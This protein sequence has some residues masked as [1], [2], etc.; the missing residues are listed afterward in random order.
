MQTRTL[1]LTPSRFITHVTVPLLIAF[2][3][4]ASGAAYAAKPAS[5]KSS[6]ESARAPQGKSGFP[7]ARQGVNMKPGTGLRSAEMTADADDCDDEDAPIAHAAPSGTSQPNPYAAREPLSKSAATAQGNAG[8]RK[9]AASTA[10]IAGTPHS[11]HTPVTVLAQS[12]VPRTVQTWEIAPSDKTLNAA[13][14][15]WARSAGW[16]LVWEL[17]VDYAVEARTTV[18]GTFE[19]AVG[20]VA[21]SMD[22]AEVPMKAIFY[23][24]NR[25]LR[26]VAKGAE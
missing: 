16:Q 18:P 19:E 23:A 2:A 7:L 4:C 13:L 17:P 24:G 10:G 26:I 22:S 5:D 15:R 1:R 8:Q 14:G 25:V 20:L 11:P 9:S 21:K 6:A 3:F 12:Y